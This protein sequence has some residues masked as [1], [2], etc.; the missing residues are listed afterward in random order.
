M[1]STVYGYKTIANILDRTAF[2]KMYNDPKILTQ[3]NVKAIPPAYRAS[4]AFVHNTVVAPLILLGLLV[5]AQNK[6]SI[7]IEANI[8]TSSN[9]EKMSFLGIFSRV[10]SS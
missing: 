4:Q 5:A 9:L 6:P 3:L 8:N 2:P 10:N 7:R 1:L